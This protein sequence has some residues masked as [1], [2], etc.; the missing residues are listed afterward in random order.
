ML[1]I[2]QM[3]QFIRFNRHTICTDVICGKKTIKGFYL[4]LKQLNWIKTWPLE[5]LKYAAGYSGS[6]VYF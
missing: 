5:S 4:L 6:S 1:I 2:P 3:H